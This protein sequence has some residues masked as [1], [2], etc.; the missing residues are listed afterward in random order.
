MAALATSKRPRFLLP[1]PQRSGARVRREVARLALRSERPRGRWG[2]EEKRTL[3]LG[4]LAAG[5]TAAVAAAEVGRV[6]RRGRAPMPSETDDLHE[7]AEEVVVETVGA[8]RAGYQD[9]PTRED[10]A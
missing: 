9:G 2:P 10:P 7:P 3:V 1:R 6:W 5:T 4:I 8:A